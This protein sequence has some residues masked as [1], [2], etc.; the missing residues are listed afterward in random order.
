LDRF[1]NP[2]T[3]DDTDEVKINGD[4]EKFIWVEHYQILI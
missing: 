4:V 1:E 3:I 2:Y